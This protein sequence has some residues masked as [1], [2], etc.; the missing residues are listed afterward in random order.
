MKR[1]PIV[2]HQLVLSPLQGERAIDSGCQHSSSGEFQLPD[3]HCSSQR[4]QGVLQLSATVR[5]HYI[6]IEVPS[7]LTEMAAENALQGIYDVKEILGLNLNWRVILYG[8]VSVRFLGA[9]SNCR[10]ALEQA[11]HTLTLILTERV[12]EMSDACFSTLVENFYVEYQ[13]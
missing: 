12:K 3:A 8:A 10:E 2:R 7:L 9:L 13:K 1:S 4:G 6:E 11:G 5:E